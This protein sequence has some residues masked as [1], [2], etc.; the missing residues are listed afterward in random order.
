MPTQ[1]ELR[2]DVRQLRLHPFTHRAA[3]KQEFPRSRLAANVRKAEKVEGSRPVPF[4]LAA[5]FGRS[6]KAN[7]PSLVRVQFQG[8]LPH[9]LAEVLQELLRLPLVLESHQHVIGIT[10][11]DD[12]AAR[13]VF[14][15]LLDPQV[16][17]VGQAHVREQRRNRRSLRRTLFAL[18]PLPVFEHACGALPGFGWLRT[19]DHGRLAAGLAAGGFGAS[20]GGCETPS[21]TGPSWAWSRRG[22]WRAWTST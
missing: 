7:Q 8:E 16:E 14:A 17:G 1:L 13:F 20:D 5:P 21:C 11:D 4:D 3:H 15:P 18:R 2:L 19:G 9:S 10:H 22:Q 12:V 6:A